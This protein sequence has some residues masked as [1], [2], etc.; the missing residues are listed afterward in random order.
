MPY[1]I[2]SENTKNDCAIFVKTNKYK[3]VNKVLCE[4]NKYV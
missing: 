1:I 4:T 3:E 2:Y